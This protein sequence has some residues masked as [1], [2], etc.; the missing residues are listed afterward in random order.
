M[1]INTQML[2]TIILYIQV[3]TSVNG[4]P[5]DL[6]KHSGVKE[7]ANRYVTSLMDILFKPEELVTF[8]TKD[9]VKDDRYNL[10]KGL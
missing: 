3:Y 1:T 8:Q 7:H 9:M 2:N 5:V 10:L 6:I 4:T